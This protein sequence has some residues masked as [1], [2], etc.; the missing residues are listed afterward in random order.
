[1]I[2]TRNP[3]LRNNS[4]IKT[5]TEIIRLLSLH[6]KSTCERIVSDFKLVAHENLCFVV[7]P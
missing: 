3:E 5:R 6:K 7:N 4:L 2:A 1:M